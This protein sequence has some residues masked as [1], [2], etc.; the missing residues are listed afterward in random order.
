MGRISI[1]IIVPC[2]TSLSRIEQTIPYGIADVLSVTG[3][4]GVNGGIRLRMVV[5]TCVHLPYELY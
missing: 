3:S 4:T 2:M 5:V 1:S